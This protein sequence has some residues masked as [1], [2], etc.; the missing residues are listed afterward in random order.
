MMASSSDSKPRLSGSS[1]GSKRQLPVLKGLKY[2]AKPPATTSPHESDSKHAWEGRDENDSDSE[3]SPFEVWQYHKSQVAVAVEEFEP[4][5]FSVEK[6]RWLAKVLEPFARCVVSADTRKERI[7]VRGMR[8]AGMFRVFEVVG[9]VDPYLEV[10][11]ARLNQPD[12]VMDDTIFAPYH[13]LETVVCRYVGLKE[14]PM[15]LLDAPMLR[16]LDLSC[17]K[18]TSFPEF[19]SSQLGRMNI[20]DLSHNDISALPK[21]ISWLKN[22]RILLL[23]DNRLT[24]LSSTFGDLENLKKLSLAHNEFSGVPINSFEKMKNLRELFLYALNRNV[25]V[26][27]IDGW[28]LALERLQEINKHV[29][30]FFYDEPARWSRIRYPASK[31]LPKNNSNN[32]N[33][34][35][36]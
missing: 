35:S 34:F 14:F 31:M 17:N 5:Y 21:S 25:E 3:Q 23:N 1:N 33:L 32:Y 29:R 28:P 18:L 27:R 22:L 20:L 8:K 36:R 4:H 15:S 10:T 30:I 24:T 13:K 12:L 26:E 7:A 19:S 16:V 9:E 2:H 6:G 11:D